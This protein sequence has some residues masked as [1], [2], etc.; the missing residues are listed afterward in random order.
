[1]RKIFSII[2]LFSLFFQNLFPIAVFAISIADQQVSPPIAS[3]D[4][5]T[6]S[7]GYDSDSKNFTLNVSSD[8]DR[9]YLLSYYDLNQDLDSSSSSEA[10]SEAKK[11]IQG[12]AKSENGIAQAVIYGGMCSNGDCVADL[13]ENGDLVLPNTNYA[14]TFEISTNQTWLR[15]GKLATTTNLEVKK[16]YVA[17]QN[18][19]VRVTFSKLPENPGK[20]FIEEVE[21]S[22]EQMKSLGAYSKVAYDISSDMK[23]GT[24][25]Y[26]LELP[27]P[28]G[29]DQKESKIIYA[30][31]VEELSV[32]KV[33]L[34]DEKK[35]SLT[36]KEVK[37]DGMNHFTVFVVATGVANGSNCT[38]ASIS[39]VCYDNLQDAVT[40]ANPNDGDG[41]DTIE[42][43]NNIVVTQ[44]VNFDKEV[45][46]DGNGFTLTSPFAGPGV[47]NS[48]N[49]PIGVSGTNV[50]IKDLI[51][52][53]IGSTSL[54]GINAY[55]ANNLLLENVTI[56]NYRAELVV[57]G[58][59][60]TVNNITTLNN[61]WGGI[62]IDQ[63]LG[64]TNPASLTVNG[65][66]SH[67]ESN[68]IWMDDFRKNVSLNDTLNQYNSEDFGNVRVFV[69]KAMPVKQISFTNVGMPTI[70]GDDSNITL[71]VKATYLPYGVERVRFRY[72]PQ[73]QTCKQQYT[74]P[75]YN[76]LGNGTKNGDFY[77]VN[78]NVT[79]LSSGEYTVCA[80][81]HRGSGMPSEGFI[82]GNYA[83]FKIVVDNTSPT[84]PVITKPISEQ[85]FKVKP[86]A[87][88]WEPAIDSGVG[89]KKY[90]VAYLYDDLHSFGGSTCNGEK[91]NNVLLSG[92]RD[93][94]GLSRN[95]SP[96]INEQGGVTIWVRAIDNLGNVGEWSDSV[97]YYYDATPPAAPTLS[98]PADGALVTG[99]PTQ[100]WTSVSDAHHYI[101]ESYLDASLLTPAYTTSI[102]GTSRVVGGNQTVA[103]WWRVKAVD[104]AG[105]ESPWSSAWKLNVDNTS[106][107]IPTLTS[108]ADE[109]FVQP[110]GLYLDWENVTDSSS[111]ITYYYQSSYGSAVGARNALTSVIYGPVP[112]NDSRINASGSADNRYYWQVKACDSLNN[113][114]DWSGP[115]EV[116]VDSSLP[117]VDL[118]FPSIGPG[119]TSFKAVY[120]EDVKKSDAENP[121]N[122][123]LTN[124]PD[125]GGSG[126]LDGDAIIEYDSASR[127]AIIT[128]S[129]PSWYVSPEQQ[130]GVKNVHDLA[131]N[132]QQINPYSEYS[133]PMVSPITVDSGI[134]SNW[135]NTSVTFN[136]ICSDTDGSGCKKTYY[137]LDG[138]DPTITSLFGNSVNVDVDG[139]YTVK[140]F[141]VDNAGNVESV[142]T[143]TNLVKIDKIDPS[144]I[145][146]TFN[147]PDEGEVGTT[148][149]DGLIQGTATDDRSGVNKVELEIS[150]DSFADGSTTKYWDGLTWQDV[151]PAT[152]I[153]A[154]GTETWSYQIPSEEVSEGIYN[155][156]SHA[157]DNAGNIE[158]TYTIKIVYDKTIPEVNLSINP[159]NADGEN[160]WYKTQ[161]QITLTADDNYKMNRIE[162]QWNST[163][164]SGWLTY[165]N[166]ISPPTE[167]Q[168]ILYYRGVDVVG[169]IGTKTTNYGVKEVKFDQTAPLAD[170]LNVRVTDIGSNTAMGRWDKPVNSDDITRYV[171]SWRH[172][173]SGDS[174]GKTVGRDDFEEELTELYDGEWVFTVKA[175]D[176]AGNYRLGTSRFTVGGG[177]G[178]SSGTTSPTDQVLGTTTDISA[179]PIN[180]QERGLISGADATT[181]ENEDIKTSEEVKPEDQGS[182]LGETTQAC[183]G[184]KYYLPLMLLI[185]QALAIIIYELLNRS[186][187]ANKIVVLF[188]STAI[189]IGLYLLLKENSCS[190]GNT[191]VAFLSKWFVLVSL[192]VSAIIKTIFYAF[193]EEV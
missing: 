156:T 56:K 84:K 132:L 101:Y 100:T 12:V 28:E 24:F 137:T 158:N 174:K 157:V 173:K 182:V 164:A 44:K 80:L 32:E 18:D 110:T 187:N 98:S 189:S 92:C 183:T 168:S 96:G 188:A 61:S 180:R 106:P 109:A 122:Y 55:L 146:T 19:Q 38:V 102:F 2:A 79:G 159:L 39:G 172:E 125:A 178:T 72:A 9:K 26:D 93:E 48:N 148:I 70:G 64:V 7:L 177:G 10:T 42:L 139:E 134:D 115:W 37:I 22:D 87:N 114:S 184:W 66:S 99:N 16:E 163:S 153:I 69:Q 111:P 6:V 46:L 65:I 47:A 126:D 190:D 131:N 169:N 176:D 11:A 57:N 152:R 140:Y 175:M 145:I 85:F 29:I 4:P 112:L 77:S 116:N 35:V 128:F 15:N 49:T 3:I 142:K 74:S 97:H 43:A 51:I 88:E 151:A 108:P 27:M 1:M 20:L 86:I 121:L 54:H 58:S 166:P 130:W 161:P 191:A 45:I 141:S 103:F 73:G 95:H 62:N 68:H 33:S 30:E 14:G 129:H 170:P 127:T 133:T 136:L 150:Y 50:V 59:S 113:C 91:I 105:N 31:S 94:L 21:L 192:A 25:E 17:P 90:Q 123:F 181:E 120:S 185:L 41:V 82:E 71:E 67:N 75:Y 160:G 144:S 165:S 81:M 23:D 117:T 52:D 13:I 63:G 83:S 8:F 147:L 193:I 34:V 53:G 149:F 78:W 124:W 104:A 89:V 162:Y 40:A 76:D 154:T 186:K 135:H 167:G 155:V 36:G 179:I 119:A 60:V 107:A 5:K 143:A 138:L 171:L 118:V